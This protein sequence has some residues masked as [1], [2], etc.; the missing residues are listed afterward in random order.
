MENKINILFI[1]HERNLGG[2]AKSLLGIVS[3]LGDDYNICILTPFKNGDFID[4]CRANNI[5]VIQRRFFSCICKKNVH[6]VRGIIEYI[7]V[8]LFAYPYNFMT[9]LILNHRIKTLNISIIHSNSSVINIGLYLS[10]LSHIKHIIHFREFVEEDFNWSF[11][12]NKKVF[13]KRVAKYTDAQIFISKV[14]KVKYDPYFE[15]HTKYVIYNG[16]DIPE[17]AVKKD[18]NLDTIKVVIVGRILLGKGQI[19]AIEAMNILIN[20]MGIKNIELHIV[21]DGDKEYLKYLRDQTDAYSLNENIF[22]E[23]YRK[24]VNEF[25]KQFDYELICS[26][27]E[28]FGRVVIEAMLCENIVIASNSGALPELIADKI[29]G[30][31]FEEKNAECIAEILFSCINAEYNLDEIRNNA[32]NKAHTE[33]TKKKNAQCIKQVYINLLAEDIA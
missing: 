32:K 25:R 12:P 29:D 17:T 7:L 2:A 27:S 15:E 14:L 16:L 23:G 28:G 1:N 18:R 6:T 19:Y 3:E 33:F 20:K 30:F 31:L 22:F 21:G 26:L 10:R 9:A 5:K 4:E 8:L 11:S 24:D 13:L